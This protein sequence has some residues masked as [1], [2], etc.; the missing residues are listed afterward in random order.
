MNVQSVSVQ[1]LV[2]FAKN[3]LPNI[4]NCNNNKNEGISFHFKIYRK[5]TWIL[6]FDGKQW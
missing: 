1:A 6:P 4:L 3:N 2:D 5:I